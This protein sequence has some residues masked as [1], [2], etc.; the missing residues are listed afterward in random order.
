MKPEAFDVAVVEVRL[1]DQYAILFQGMLGGEDGLA[2]LR[3]SGSGRSVQ[4]LWTSWARL[5][6]VR[7]WLDSLPGFLQVEVVRET[8]ADM[9][10]I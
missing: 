1:P 4:Q 7:E 5:P 3:C 10:R 6:E 2:T 9:E 8:V